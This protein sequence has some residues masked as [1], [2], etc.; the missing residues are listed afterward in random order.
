MQDQSTPEGGEAAL[1]RE[2][3]ALRHADAVRRAT[4]IWPGVIRRETG[5]V[6]TFDPGP[7]NPRGGGR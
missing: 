7:V 4:G 6:L 3:A 2:E 1:R 5:P